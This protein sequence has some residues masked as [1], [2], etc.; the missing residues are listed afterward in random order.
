MPAPAGMTSARF[1]VWAGGSVAR[2]RIRFGDWKAVESEA[3]EF[4]TDPKEASPA[5]KDY[6]EGLSLYAQG[7]AAVE[8]GEAKPAAK[9]SEAL[10]AMLWRLEASKSKE[11]GE[12][13]DK[14]K[15]PEEEDDPGEV[16][17]ILCAMSL[18]LRANVKSL[19]GEDDEAL[20]LFEKALE[21]EKDLGYSEPPQFFRP[22][23][24]SVGEAYLKNHQWGKA[25]DAFELALKQRPKSGHALYGI[26]RS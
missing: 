21:N 19:E 12:D 14:D 2:L 1:A 23:Q 11:K 20:E 3:I 6:A 16:L 15:T 10:D 7:M 17:D 26:A 18:D 25:R 4:G 5:A 8:K 22:E 24:E 9:Q 13:K